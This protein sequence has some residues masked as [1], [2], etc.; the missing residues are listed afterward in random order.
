MKKSAKNYYV[1]LKNG[2]GDKIRQLVPKYD[3]MTRCIIDL[4]DLCSPA[5]VLDIGAG[6]GNLSLIVLREI[7]GVQ[8]TT[9]EASSEMIS[10]AREALK[11]DANQVSLLHRDIL[12][13]SP[14]GAFDA[15]FTDLV[16]HNIPFDRKGELI[17]T[18]SGWLNPGGVFIWGDLI[19]Y[20]DP[21]IQDHFI[22]QRIEHALSAGCSKGLVKRNFE[23][24]ETEDWPLTIE[25]TLSVARSAGFDDPQNVWTHDTFA[26]FF[27]RKKGQRGTIR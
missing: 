13:F 4:L 15:I 11:S 16:L 10:E 8:L 6:V 5:T 27:L 17:S 19:R 18:I 25:E 12:D 20:R 7:P 21:Q 1:E 24:E 2:Y 26:V 3:D 23:K 22:R 9:V 14:E